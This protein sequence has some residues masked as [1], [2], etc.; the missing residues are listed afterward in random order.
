MLR[1]KHSETKD[2]IRVETDVWPSARQRKRS[3]RAHEIGRLLKSG[4][5]RKTLLFFGIN[6]PSNIYR[7]SK[8]KKLAYSAA[9]S[10]MKRLERLGFVE[11][12]SVIKNE[13]GAVAKL[14]GLSLKGFI[15]TTRYCRSQEEVNKVVQIWRELDKSGLLEKWNYL[16]E[17]VGDASALVLVTT[18]IRDESPIDKCIQHVLYHSTLYET[19]DEFAASKWMTLL[20]DDKELRKTTLAHI[21]GRIEMTNKE[22]AELYNEKKFYE[23]LRGVFLSTK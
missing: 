14:Y 21:E 20:T 5:L 18:S 6:G 22:I 4:K 12:V 23:K 8:R 10:L 15:W 3:E 16:I 13:K 7:F 1:S 11:V 19:Y 9:H 17:K 2:D